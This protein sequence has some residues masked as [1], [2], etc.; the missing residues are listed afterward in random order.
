M[1]AAPF[2]IAILRTGA[3]NIASVASGFARLGGRPRLIDDADSVRTA[4]LLVSPGVGSFG[5]AIERLSSIGALDALRAR[6][7]SGRPTLTICLGMQMLF[8]GSEES[9]EARGLGIA[10][11]RVTAF[12]QGARRP[13]M[14]WNEVIPQ[15]D[16]PI[17]ARGF[18]YFAN[19]FRMTDP[20][21]GWTVALTDHA[22]H[23]ISAMRR[24]PILACQFHPEL[25]GAFG[26]DLMTGWIRAAQEAAP[27]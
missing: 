16:D 7:E 1:T 4:P 11:G 2:D 25:S 9:P 13:H 27:C 24:G 21:D 17:L 6:V 22:G 14:G 18:A 5:A 20:P 12:P 8:E 15:R 19:S 23:F 10:P 3:A 26:L